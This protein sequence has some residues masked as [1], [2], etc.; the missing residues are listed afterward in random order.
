MTSKQEQALRECPFCGAGETIS[1]GNYMP[2]VDMSGKPRSLISWEIKHWCEKKA[3]VVAQSINIRGREESDAIAAWNTRTPDPSLL[4]ALKT[5]REAFAD[6]IDTVEDD[7]S[8][9]AIHVYSTS[10]KALTLITAAL[11]ENA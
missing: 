7:E 10:N 4:N 1:E 5:A 8:G 2:G 6:I 9:N 3:G 11:G